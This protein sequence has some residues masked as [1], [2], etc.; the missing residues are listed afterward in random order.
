MLD[1]TNVCTMPVKKRGRPATGAAKTA[2]Q[3]K[4]VQREKD[5]RLVIDAI[6][7]ELAATE[8]ALI[9]LLQ[10]SEHSAHRAWLALGIQKGWI[11]SA[12]TDATELFNVTITLNSLHP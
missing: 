6:G 11:K 1:Q 7:D 4:Q 9:A 2:Q 8:K 12:A 3:R 10:T 5:K